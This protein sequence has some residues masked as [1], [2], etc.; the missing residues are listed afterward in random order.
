MPKY[1]KKY[2]NSKN[3]NIVLDE[4]KGYLEKKIEEF[5]SN[6]EIEKS[7]LYSNLKYIINKEYNYDK[8]ESV[9]KYC[10]LKYFIIIFKKYKFKIKPIFPFMNIIIN[11]KLKETECDD[12]F[13]K[14]KYKNDIITNN[15]V[16]GDFFEASVKFGLVK[17]KFP[18]K[19]DYISEMVNEIVSM[20][21]IIDK[22]NRY[23]IEENKGDNSEEEDE[24]K[25]INN[26]FINTES[27]QTVLKEKKLDNINDN[28]KVEMKKKENESI[29]VEE[30]EENNN[31]DDEKEEEFEIEEGEDEDEEEE[32]KINI[33]KKYNLENIQETKEEK[34]KKN[35][36]KVTNKELVKLL[37]T[38]KIKTDKETFKEEGL[39]YDA[40]LLMKNIEDYRIDEINEQLYKTE[41]IEESGFNG[42]ESIFLDQLSKWGKALDFAYLYGNKNNKIFLG[43]QMKCYF[44]NSDLN[45]N[46]IDKNYIKKSCRKI[47]VNSMKLFN[48]KIVKW[49]YYL[50][51][52]YNPENKNE[53]I[54]KKNLDKCDKNNICYFFYEPKK[55]V[56]FIKG[57]KKYIKLKG[58][59]LNKNANLD[60][61]IIDVSKFAFEIPRIQKELLLGEELKEMK[62]SFSKDLI[63]TFKMEKN[64][65][66]T[67]ILDKIKLSIDAKGYSLHFH[68]KC[69]FNKAIICPKCESFVFLY[70]KK[71][72]EK[73]NIDKIDFIAAFIEEEVVKYIELSSQ[74]I[75]DHIY[76]VIDEDSKY[77]YCLF[78][79]KEIGKRTK[80]DLPER[81]KSE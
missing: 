35:K 54:S 58:V 39:S 68:A 15:Y 46:V 44:I 40:K 79:F 43:F 22:N 27:I 9:I 80:K 57:K 33:N 62:E 64:S 61:N 7:L 75:I 3:E 25:E 71:N 65:S 55:K 59:K 11:Y 17:L 29:S 70:K 38:F 16:K 36:R 6:Y 81:L 2:K 31:N 66:I 60:Y 28:Q 14:E 32:E 4:V 41:S 23:F 51:F 72:Q 52:Y 5:C 13:K 49:F 69:E 76:D 20:D 63:K 12:Y 10:L 77:Y 26:K 18:E 24:E 34:D 1:V 19:D 78:K 8:F 50:I 73:D 48:C 74:K 30:E 67:D 45:N 56:F 42:D 37:K 47:L 21:K 53:N